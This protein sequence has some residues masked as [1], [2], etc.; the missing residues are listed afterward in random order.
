MASGWP[1]SESAARRQRRKRRRAA[2]CTGRLCYG[3][4]LGLGELPDPGW[5]W[6]GHQAEETQSHT[7]CQSFAQDAT[8]LRDEFLEHVRQTFSEA[9][10]L[11]KA[12]LVYEVGECQVGASATPGVDE[13][14]L[15]AEEDAVGVV[16]VEGSAAVV[17]ATVDP[18]TLVQVEEFDRFFTGDMVEV[19]GL[20]RARHLNGCRGCVVEVL[21]DRVGFFQGHVEPKALKGFNL[22]KVPMITKVQK[23]DE[24]PQVEFVDQ[25]GQAPVT[26]R[27][28][29]I[30]EVPR[31]SSSTLRRSMSGSL[32]P[33]GL[34]ARGLRRRAT[35]STRTERSLPRW[36]GILAWRCGASR[37]R[38]LVFKP[39]PGRQ[40]VQAVLRRAA[41]K[42]MRS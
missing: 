34:Y 38:C 19:L 2:I 24:G 11:V 17:R 23:T 3:G 1:L 18:S 25:E 22:R 21:S 35:T 28:Q 15:A 40:D 13:V 20:Q 9:L 30:V 14:L 16:A 8:S 36:A 26:T 4:P 29:K 39:V 27:V 42:A 37:S 6:W 41:W 32:L 12:E 5:M 10:K 33:E 31:S 7:H